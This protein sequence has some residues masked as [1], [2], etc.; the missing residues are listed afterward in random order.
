MR[1]PNRRAG[2]RDFV[3]TVS[4]DM[5]VP[6]RYEAE[7]EPAREIEADVPLGRRDGRAIW[8]VTVPANGTAELRFRS[9]R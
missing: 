8:A 5:A 3:L 4:N 6:V 9:E 7:F 1:M 2:E